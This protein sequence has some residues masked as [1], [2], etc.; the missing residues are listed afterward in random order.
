MAAFQPEAL[1]RRLEAGRVRYVVIGGVAAT[2]H[3]SPLVT[4]DSDICPAADA[5]NLRAL[6]AA[7]RDL[8]AR[9][10]T[11]NDPAGVAFACDEAFLAEAQLLNL[12]TRFGDLDIVLEP[13]AGGTGGYVD[14]I[15]RAVRFDLGEGLVVPGRRCATSSARKKRPIAFCDAGA[16]TLRLLLEKQQD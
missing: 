10:R 12:T 6:A 13:A 9:I 15:S 8:D 2:L 1:L 7:L 14:L 11:P 16:P 5:A 3:G 4:R